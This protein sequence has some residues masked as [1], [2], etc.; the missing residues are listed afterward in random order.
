MP[1]TLDGATSICKE[2]RVLLRSQE[3]TTRVR[4]ILAKQVAIP[5]KKITV[6]LC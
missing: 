1:N 6:H 5:P 2:S 4:H 3:N